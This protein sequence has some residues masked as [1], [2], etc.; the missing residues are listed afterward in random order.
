LQPLIDN[1]LYLNPAT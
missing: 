1:Q